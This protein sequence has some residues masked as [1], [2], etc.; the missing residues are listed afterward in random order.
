VSAAVTA[1]EPLRAL[2]LGFDGFLGK[3][4]DARAVQGA[5]TALSRD[6]VPGGIHWHTRTDWWREQVRVYSAARAG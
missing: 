3:P 5:L 2:H 6:G 4:V 1:N